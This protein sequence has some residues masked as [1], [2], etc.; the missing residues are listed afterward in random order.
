M[1]TSHATNDPTPEERAARLM[2]GRRD[3]KAA[4]EARAAQQRRVR[5]VTRFALAGG[6]VGTGALTAVVQHQSAT[7]NKTA[8]VQ[9]TSVPSSSATANGA[10]TNAATA[11]QSP[12][13]QPAATSQAAQVVSGGS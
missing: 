10:T 9:S 13:T 6:L 7:T 4:R 3:P 5:V 8:T 2:A 11:P 12:A 1:A